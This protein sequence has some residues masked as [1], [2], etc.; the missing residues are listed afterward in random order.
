VSNIAILNLSPLK[1]RGISVYVST[2][3]TPFHQTQVPRNYPY[4]PVPGHDWTGFDLTVTA[5]IHFLNTIEPTLYPERWVEFRDAIFDGTSGPL[6][7]PDLGEIN[8]CVLDGSFRISAQTTAGIIVTVTWSQTRDDVEEAVEFGTSGG[9]TEQA[10]AADEALEE[11]ELEYPDGEPDTSLGETVGAIEGAVF[12]Y[13]QQI[14]GAINQAQGLIGKHLQAIDLMGQAWRFADPTGRDAN[15]GNSARATAETSLYNLY[16]SLGKRADDAAKKARPV[17]V[18]LVKA[19]TP[20]T[21]L[22]AALGNTL[23]ELLGLNPSLAS[24]PTVPATSRV[25]HYV[26]A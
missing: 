12:S 19:S 22:A 25:I 2:I 7:H 3:E 16:A 6:E 1:W 13:G 26:K 20:M 11:L 10:E 5:T 24:S 23:D 21:G 17:A 8:A 18:H 4:V 14:G 9:D 15:A